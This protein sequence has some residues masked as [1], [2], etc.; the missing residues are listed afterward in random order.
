MTQDDRWHVS[1]LLG[2]R[3]KQQL[4]VHP[5]ITNK[6]AGLLD[7]LAR[8]EAEREVLASQ[9]A[10]MCERSDPDPANDRE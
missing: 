10:K 3:L 4:P 2:G 5:G 1:K 9:N 8:A 6:M 7:I